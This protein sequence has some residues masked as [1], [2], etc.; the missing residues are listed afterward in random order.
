[1]LVI[2]TS[3]LFPTCMKFVKALIILELRYKWTSGSV[4][5]MLHPLCPVID[6]SAPYTY[7]AM[8]D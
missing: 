2:I 7:A 8:S 1:M 4:A 3:V 6:R 5:S